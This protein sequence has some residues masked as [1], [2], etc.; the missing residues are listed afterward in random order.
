MN[1]LGEGSF[2]CV[3]KGLIKIKLVK[4]ITDGINYALKKIK[5]N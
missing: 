1:K 4:R 5:M 2:S 3:Y